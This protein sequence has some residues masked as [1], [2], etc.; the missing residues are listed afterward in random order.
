MVI[1]KCC[2]NPMLIG[3]LSLAGVASIRT[4][5]KTLLFTKCTALDK[6]VKVGVEIF[7]G[8]KNL[9]KFHYIRPIL[10]LAFN[11]LGRIVGCRAFSASLSLH[12]SAP[13]SPFITLLRFSPFPCL[14][15]VLH[16][17]EKRQRVLNSVALPRLRLTHTILGLV[18]FS[19]L[20]IIV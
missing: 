4:S 13:L 9:I 8:T 2:S 10:S 1:V 12:Y 3:L 17:A 16:R 19:N 18:K 5:S 20:V 14:S 15:P 7:E 11:T 6:K